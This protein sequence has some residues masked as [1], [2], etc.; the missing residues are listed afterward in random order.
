MNKTQF[1]ISRTYFIDNHFEKTPLIFKKGYVG[2]DFTWQELDSAIYASQSSP[3]GIKVFNNGPIEETQYCNKCI[4]LGVAKKQLD[5]DQIYRELDAGATIIFDRI[6][7]LSL[8]IRE[9]CNEISQF[10]REDVIANGYLSFGDKGSFGDHWDTHDVFAVQL[11]GRK[12]W[13]LYYPT[14]PLPVPGQTSKNFKHCRPSTPQLD[15]I[16]EPGDIL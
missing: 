9:I 3:L 14:F 10:I 12:R 2:Q 6:E 5:R 16:L 8:R 7:S 4:E 15:L 13:L 11:L 1:K